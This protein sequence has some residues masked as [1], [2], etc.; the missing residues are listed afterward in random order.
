MCTKAFLK[1][2]ETIKQHAE[3]KL[4]K[5]ELG[6]LHERDDRASDFEKQIVN[7]FFL[8]QYAIFFKNHPAFAVMYKQM[9]VYPL[10]D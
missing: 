1:A 5:K 3:F 10:T 2:L 4:G 7:G 6:L 8:I 9:R